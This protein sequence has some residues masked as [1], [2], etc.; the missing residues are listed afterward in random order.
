[1]ED[2]FLCTTLPLLGPVVFVPAPLVA[3]RVTPNSLSVLRLERFAMWVDVFN[4]LRDRYEGQ[5]NAKLLR[6]FRGAYAA[7]RR[8]YAK[9][10]MGACEAQ[11]ARDQLWR[12]VGDCRRLPS[13]LKSMALLFLTHMPSLAQPKW[14]S[15]FRE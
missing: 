10:L 11:L 1:V 12:S 15:R 2:S 6:A 5:A 14:P 8:S 3:Y 13:M 4:I 7:K 9:I